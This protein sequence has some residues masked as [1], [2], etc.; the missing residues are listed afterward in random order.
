[1]PRNHDA[2]KHNLKSPYPLPLPWLHLQEA[3]SCAIIA[4]LYFD[5]L[6]IL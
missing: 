3:F 4:L 1:M 6:R 5:F 2:A